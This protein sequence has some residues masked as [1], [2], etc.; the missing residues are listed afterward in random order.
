[1]SLVGSGGPVGHEDP[2]AGIE[3]VVFDKDGTLIDFH[4]MWAG[5]MVGLADRL[6]AAARRP[7][8]GPLFEE[9]GFDP[10]T[11]QADPHGPLAAMP[12]N[13]LRRRTIDLVVAEGLTSRA[14]AS[15]VDGAWQP[16]DPVALARPLTDLPRLLGALRAQGR[17]LAVATSDERAPTERTL[18]ALQIADL[19]DALVCADDGV[20]AKPAPDMVFHACGR[21]GI[22]AART[23]VVGDAPVDLRMGRAAGVGRCIG[24]L[25]GTG[26]RSQLAPDA[27]LILPSVA[28]LLGAE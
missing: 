11:G 27:D 10:L 16:P 5:W 20:P 22:A 15:A 17:R 18:A 6:E 23:A 3:L 4:A 9:L 12:M 13:V 28:A 19:L 25:S 8:R 1:M 26:S 7:L 2:L 24:V 14:A 21:L